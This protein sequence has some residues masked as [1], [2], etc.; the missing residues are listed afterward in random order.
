MKPENDLV[1]AANNELAIATQFIR[2]LI[3]STITRKA[4]T[5]QPAL[6]KHSIELTEDDQVLVTSEDN[7]IAVV[8]IR[9]GFEAFLSNGDEIA[10]AWITLFSEDFIHKYF[11]EISRAFS[12]LQSKNI[13]Y[14]NLKNT[15][16]LQRRSLKWGY[17]L[18]MNSSK[19][20]RSHIEH[21]CNKVGIEPKF[22]NITLPTIERKQ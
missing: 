6:T 12:Y 21:C 3:T 4:T 14:S 22:G 13:I 11:V 7:Y 8:V 5:K 18:L 1:Q 15:T 19:A 2:N 17:S 20:C 16:F 9:Y 10:G